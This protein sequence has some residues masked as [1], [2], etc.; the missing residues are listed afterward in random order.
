MFNKFRVVCSDWR[1]EGLEVERDH[2]ADLYRQDELYYK[3]LYQ[4]RGG[5]IDKHMF[6]FG[7]DPVTPEHYLSMGYKAH[8]YMVDITVIVSDF[9]GDCTVYTLDVQ[10]MW[11]RDYYDL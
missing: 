5:S 2:S 10:V 4:P 1:D 11:S 3:F 7:N 9:I 6:H 8:E